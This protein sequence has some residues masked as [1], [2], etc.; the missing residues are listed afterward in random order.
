VTT[1]TPPG[2]DTESAGAPSVLEINTLLGQLRI[3]KN[4]VDNKEWLSPE[5]SGGQPGSVDA[6]SS[7]GSP[8]STLGSSGMDFLTPMVSFLDEP[9]DQ[10][11]GDPSSVTSGATEFDSAGQNASAL[12]EEYRSTSD[13]Q[14][15]EWSGQSA[16]DYLS[17]GTEMADGILSIAETAL[18]SPM[19]RS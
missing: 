14:A 6:V 8:L 12:A 15:S 18:T 1:T 13:G 3:A 10:L 9:L 19:S 7:T 11:R 4:A 17:K 2:A 16:T 5:L